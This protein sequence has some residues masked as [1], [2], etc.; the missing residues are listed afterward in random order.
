[1]RKTAKPEGLKTALQVLR[2][3]SSY[4]WDVLDKDRSPIGAQPDGSP[5]FMQYL[6]LTPE[7][8]H[9]H[10]RGTCWEHTE[11]QHRLYKDLGVPHKV[12]YIE[13]D[14]PEK[15]S[16][17]VVLREDAKG[18]VYW[19]ETAWKDRTGSHRFD[20]EKDALDAIARQVGKHSGAQKARVFRIG[21]IPGGKNILQY[22]KAAK[23]GKP[24]YAVDLKEHES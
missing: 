24:V 2:L 20:T 10:K 19:D 17:T 1:M 11:A 22:M 13:A 6:T 3:L 15:G 14:N 12:F 21:S 9:K 4:R 23:T 7:E 5:D 8:L 16:H 18:G